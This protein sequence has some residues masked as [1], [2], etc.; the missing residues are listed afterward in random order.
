MRMRR[1]KTTKQSMSCSFSGA[2][3]S[4]RER[5]GSGQAASPPSVVGSLPTTKGL[6]GVLWM[7]PA[8]L[9]F[10]LITF[11]S[12][13]P[14]SFSG[15]PAAPGRSRTLRYDVDYTRDGCKRSPLSRFHPA[16]HS[17]TASMSS[18]SDVVATAR[19]QR[20]MPQRIATMILIVT[21]MATPFPTL[22][23]ADGHHR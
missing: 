1:A 14:P 3:P 21:V 11:F 8:A 15:S 16:L 23:A 2:F 7:V 10:S 19:F 13:A 18:F 5:Q 17:R 22:S 20:T 4:G 6:P 9:D 12:V